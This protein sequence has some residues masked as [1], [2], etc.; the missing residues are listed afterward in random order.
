MAFAPSRAVY[1]LEA[2]G[3][4]LALVE[5]NGRL[6]DAAIAR[7]TALLNGVI[8]EGAAGIVVDLRGCTWIDS[9][10]S[11]ALF[12]ASSEMTEGTDAAMRLVTYAGSPVDLELSGLAG[13]L[14]VHGSVQ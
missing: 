10:C 4:G 11:S 5:V 7:W 8:A 13:E 2:L 3:P 9:A 12:R 1:H 6:Q 14:P